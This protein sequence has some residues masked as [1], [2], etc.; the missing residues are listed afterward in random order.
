MADSYEEDEQ[1]PGITPTGAYMTSEG[2]SVEL[3]ADLA[4]E[5]ELPSTEEI[6]RKGRESHD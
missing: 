3:D 1:L 2:S 6:V 4:T 5:E